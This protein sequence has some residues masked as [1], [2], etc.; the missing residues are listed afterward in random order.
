ME[1]K[2]PLVSVII[3]VYNAQNTIDNT[4][5]SVINQ[6]YTNLEIIIVNDGSTDT[7][8]DIIKKYM[9]NDSRIV[10]FDKQN[11][12]LVQARKSGIDVATGKYIQY[13]DSDDTLHKD[14]IAL[15][16]DKAE[17]T[18]ADIVVAPFLFCNDNGNSEKSMFLDFTE[19]S[20]VEYLKNIFKRKA[21]WC[22]WSK[23]HLRSLYQNKIERLDISFGEDV[24][25]S[26]QLLLYAQKVVSIDYVIIDY[27]FTS[28]S[29][30][31]PATFDNKKYGDFVTYV[32][33][34]DNFLTS[35][36][37]KKEFQECF[38]FLSLENT[39][40]RIYWKRFADVDREMRKH[41]TDWAAFPE[42]VNTLTKRER[43]ILNSYKK[44][45]LIGHLRLLYYDWR[46][47]I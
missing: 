36:G 27:N 21:Y 17:K 33:W 44:S 1:E 22:V 9:L 13:L 40:R 45:I 47:K 30:S 31:H 11:E 46:G 18:H 28:V 14:A 16:I 2:C 3:P 12:G 39:F 19:L 29:M 15:L 23:F 26:T 7:S 24:I 38:A 4:L 20:G 43:K 32:E 10:L 42:L 37:L 5:L 34:L 8:L 6:T 41:L 35:K 25:L